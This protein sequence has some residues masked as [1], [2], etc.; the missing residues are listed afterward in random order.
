MVKKHIFVKKPAFTMI[1]LL[2]VITII[3][4]LSAI[5]LNAYDDAQKRARDAR[6]RTEIDQIM[7][8]ITAYVG[9]NGIAPATDGNYGGNGTCT[10][11]QL[12]FGC[13]LTG[14]T[15]SP[16]Y[17]VKV[18][19]APKNGAAACGVGFVTTCRH[20][21]YQSVPTGVCSAPG[22][23]GLEGKPYVST[24]ME[25]TKGN[26]DDC[27]TGYSNYGLYYRQP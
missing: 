14:T 18:P 20:Y 13:P 8:A 16:V 15:G 17:M 19:T 21:Y 11:G 1:E 6:R 25:T 24:Y 9:D 10:A 27:L 5:G 3:G 4:I 12:V 26:G 2:V 23:T 7:K 22:G